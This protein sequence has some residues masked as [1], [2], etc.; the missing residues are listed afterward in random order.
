MYPFVSIQGMIANDHSFV[1]MPKKINKY[2]MG[3]KPVYEVI[4]QQV[5]HKLMW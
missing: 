2:L 4:E 5:Y 3:L 1:V